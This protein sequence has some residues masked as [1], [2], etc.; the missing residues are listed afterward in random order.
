MAAP[1]VHA[2]A[3]NASRQ[4]A[5]MEAA[6]GPLAEEMKKNAVEVLAQRRQKGEMGLDV[7][8]ADGECERVPCAEALCRH[9]SLSGLWGVESM[10]RG[11]PLAM[12]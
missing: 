12:I 7:D 2:A 6:G 11:A 8:D 5:S 3:T 4:K 9:A 1:L 10:P